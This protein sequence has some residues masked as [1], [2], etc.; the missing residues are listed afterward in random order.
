MN[1]VCS[2]QVE[3][4]KFDYEKTNYLAVMPEKVLI[5]LPQPEVFPRLTQI[6]ES[7][8]PNIQLH[9]VCDV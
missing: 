6:F 3:G 4:D 2:F 8:T 5:P 1:T 9:P 7:P